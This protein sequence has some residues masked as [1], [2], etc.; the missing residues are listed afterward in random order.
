MLYSL[1]LVVD[2]AVAIQNMQDM[3]QP[4]MET[5][6]VWAVKVCF[7]IISAQAFYALVIRLIKL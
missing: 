3:V 6:T 2:P 5:A 1:L 4:V 7:M